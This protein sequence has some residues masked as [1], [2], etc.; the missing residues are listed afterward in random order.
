V[1]DCKEWATGLLSGELIHEIGRKA[2]TVA[3]HLVEALGAHSVEGG[4]FG[5]L[6]RALASQD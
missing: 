3:A 5:I 1:G 6:Q 2:F 4:K